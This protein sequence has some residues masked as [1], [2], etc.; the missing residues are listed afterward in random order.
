MADV[1]QLVARLSLDMRQFRSEMVKATG[2][3][4]RAARDVESAWAKTNG[5]LN[6]YG[7]SMARGLIAPLSGI[8]AA[9]S[10]REVAAYADAWLGAKN[11]LAVAGVVGENQIAILD[12]LYNSAQANAAPI[13]AL[14]DLYGKGAQ[15]ADNLGASQEDLLKFSDGVAV[16]LR[17]AGKS[18]AQSS[19]AL[20]QLGQLLGQARVQAEEF[21]SVNE[22][23][24]PIL[25]AVAAGLD[26]A[27]GSVSKLKTLVNDGKVSGKQFFEA[28]LKGLPAIQAMAANSTQTIE[29][30][31]TKINNAFTKYVGE[32]DA[33]LGATARLTQGLNYLANDFENIAD[34]TLKLAAIIAGALVGRSIAGM[35]VKLGLGTAA[36]YRFVAALTAARSVA[37][38]ATAIGGLGAV[39]GP[40]GL[41]VGT[42]LTGAL[43]A[44]GTE[45][46]KASSAADAYTK[47][48]DEVKAAAGGASEAI[49]DFAGKQKSDSVGGIAIGEAEIERT[50]Q[51]AAKL[52]QEIIDNAPRRLISAD[53]IK[54]LQELQTGLASG[55]TEATAVSDALFAL[56]ESNPK[57]KKLADQ[58]QP[59]L[60]VLEQ[61][62]KA[63][64]K[65]KGGLSNLGS[66]IIP[67]GRGQETASLAADR[68]TAKF[69]SDRDAESKRTEQQKKIDTRT[70]AIITAADKV[71]IAITEA[72]AKIQAAKEIAAEDL[73]QTT[74]KSVSSAMELIKQKEG[75][76][77]TP[78]FDVN[79]MRAG[80]GS[81]TVT[82]SDG[83]IQKVTAGMTVTL[84][85]ANRDLARRI[86]EF[87]SGIKKAIGADKFNA[88]TE[89][90]QAVLTSIAY[91]YGSLPDRI[92]N[93][94]ATGDAGAVYTAIRGL[95]G[96]NGGVNRKRRNS[97]AE[98]FA[99]GGGA[100]ITSAVAAGESQDNFAKKLEEQRQYIAA[101][102]AETGIRQ[103][104]NPL[105]NDYGQAMTA[106]EVAQTLLT[107]AQ[108]DGI[109]AGLEL[110][111]IQQLLYGDLSG[112]SPA[113]REQAMA[114]RELALSTGTAEAADNRLEES[115]KNL[116]ETLRQSSAFGKDVLGGF[117]RDLRDGKSATEALA[118]ALGKVADKLLDM[119]LNSLFD[120]AGGG[121][122]G[123]LGS[124]FSFL[125]NAKGG[126]VQDGKRL[127]MMAKGGI[128]KSIAIAGEAGP[129]A[130]VPLP[131]GKR[132]PVVLSQ[133]MGPT[134]RQGGSNDVVTLTL[135]DDSGRMADIANQQIRTSAGTIVNIA[136]QQSR[137]AV[138]ADMPN[139]INGAQTRQM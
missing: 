40:V 64:E 37:G 74:A 16:S 20:T 132:I 102:Q 63:T 113:A 27:G 73:A 21:N 51:A 77:A 127:P 42:V 4:A 3:N 58:I 31:I 78:Y 24:R 112:L 39:A 81:D 60:E 15:A 11:A 137:R 57:F 22:G 7:R 38:V 67:D 66:S 118:N 19:G 71:G 2:V 129:E 45:S 1:E 65:L 135:Q 36:I 44:F 133:P 100:G 10:V 53:Q 111:D 98:L 52:F 50:R 5:K 6:G 43:I 119:A 30:G 101:L 41:A 110:S 59:L 99:Q 13:T 131:D 55:T 33:S 12:K 25:M 93:A 34:T 130:I 136:V 94:I 85:D 48:L 17:V 47:A 117:I 91:N 107:A 126:I 87:Q 139:L 75:F 9:A 121:G 29:Q 62:V 125:F 76:R 35:I 28:F 123:P 134:G 84:E 49:A 116:Q 88:M 70:E 82:L 105:V 18:A 46:G 56:A 80:F 69:L 120:G 95:G 115:Q 108:E 54:Q 79:A 68:A 96:D 128:T 14:A 72:A 104:L 32:T 23:A 8:A 61:S 83:S 124:L 86:E 106:V 114:M 138:K 90:Q 122:G 109:E 92:V 26:E 103:T 89:Q 97:E